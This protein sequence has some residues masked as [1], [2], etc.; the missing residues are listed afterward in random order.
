[1]SPGP[2]SVRFSVRH[3][4]FSRIEG[5]FR[6]FSGEVVAPGEDFSGAR[7]VTTIPV[8]SVYTRHPDRDRELLGEDFF[9]AERYPN[10]RFASTEVVRTGERTFDIAGELT[11]RGVTRPVLLEAEHEG[12]RALSQ[13]RL[14]ADFRAT[15]SINRY[16]FGLAWNEVAETGGILVGETVDITLDI[17]LVREDRTSKR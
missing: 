1:M 11:I 15:G 4:V 17:A 6:K 9:W 16:D 7:I 13:G 8:A 5:S 14:R 12:T 10:I 3:L 2:S